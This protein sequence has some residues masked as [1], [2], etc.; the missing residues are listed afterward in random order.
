M[1]G[2]YFS[3]LFIFAIALSYIPSFRR[4]QKKESTKSAVIHFVKRYL[5]L[6][7]IGIAMNGINNILDGDSKPLNYA[8]IALTA[9]ILLVGLVTLILRGKAKKV[10]GKILGGL[11][12]FA[13]VAGVI[14][15]LV[16]FI[17]LVTGKTRDSL[18]YWLVLHH[19]GF[20]GLVALPFA[21]I[22][23]KKG[24]LVRF[25]AGF[26]MLGLVAL[27]HEGDLAND[28]FASNLELVD[29][30]ADGGFAGGFA[31]GAMLILFTA[32]SDLYYE[33]KK[34]FVAATAIYLVPVAAMLV[35]IFKTLPESDTYAGA[36]S[37]FLPINKGSVS[38]SYVL[39]SIA[40]ALIAFNIYDLF[41]FYKG[42]FDPLSWWGKNPI[43]LYIIEFA[44]IGG[45]TAALGGFFETAS[46][47]VSVVIVIATAVLLTLLAYILDKKNIILKL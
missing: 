47:V 10:C 30:V 15:A 45:L 9:L 21:L 34:K 32:F 35:A 18:G 6:V 26:G 1:P 8:I 40:L 37:T 46:A 3:P 42:K 12:I 22:K 31:W 44:V 28:L 13:G 7:G 29:C 2:H 11:V 16:N 33:C 41:N 43:L 27:F 23:G 38:P 5:S 19:I 17:L 36:L 14:I 20:A 4:R 24:T 39:V 25:I